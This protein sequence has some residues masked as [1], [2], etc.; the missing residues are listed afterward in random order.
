MIDPY[1]IFHY[2]R[3]CKTKVDGKKLNY[4][5]NA[6]LIYAIKQIGIYKAPNE[7]KSAYK[8]GIDYI[9]TT[10]RLM[11]NDT[12]YKTEVKRLARPNL[13]REHCLYF[14]KKTLKILECIVS[15]IDMPT[16]GT[17]H[18]N[19]MIARH[20]F[21]EKKQRPNLHCYYF[22][23]FELITHLRAVEGQMDHRAKAYDIYRELENH[24][25]KCK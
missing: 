18:N 4:C 6:N 8:R 3:F 16:D 9:C 17:T 15:C 1:L 20:V 14:P 7:K 24:P 22:L 19:C 25:K 23:V 5:K 13:K 21:C 11:Y 10:Y 12:L 2:L